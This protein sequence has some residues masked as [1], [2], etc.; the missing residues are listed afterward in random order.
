MRQNFIELRHFGLSVRST[1]LPG[2]HDSVGVLH[3]SATKAKVPNAC[4]FHLMAESKP[5]IISDRRITG[6]S[7]SAVR[8]TNTDQIIELSRGSYLPLHTC[9]MPEPVAEVLQARLQLQLVLHVP[10]QLL[11][12]GLQFFARLI[13]VI[14]S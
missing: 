13:D 1:S 9:T 12:P 14:L 7:I 4:L 5:G 8:A 6:K 11:Q 2:N 10:G 3:E